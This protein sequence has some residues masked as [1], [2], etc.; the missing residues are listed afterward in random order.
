[1]KISQCVMMMAALVVVWTTGAAPTE[2][3][4][5]GKPRALPAGAPREAP[6]GPVDAPAEQPGVGEPVPVVVHP[7]E[8]DGGVPAV[9]AVAVPAAGLPDNSVGVPAAAGVPVAADSD[10]DGVGVG[11]VYVPPDPESWVEGD[12]P[13]SVDPGLVLAGRSRVGSVRRCPDLC[14]H[15]V[16]MISWIK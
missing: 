10:S 14:K 5:G 15:C 4:G 9:P 11:D 2:E 13:Y 12:V 1:M 8:D 3:D 6:T 7:A 16:N